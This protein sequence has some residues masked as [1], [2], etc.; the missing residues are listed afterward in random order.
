MLIV[1]QLSLCTVVIATRLNITMVAF[2]AS[3]PL[4]TAAVQYQ[5]PAFNLA[6]EDI[7]KA[8][9]FNVTFAPIYLK[10]VQGCP[11][12]STYNYL[13]PEYY[14]QRWERNGQ[15]I[16]LGPGCE[17]LEILSQLGRGLFVTVTDR[18][19]LPA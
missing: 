1:L 3:H 14:Y 6:I 10:E 4:Y 7:T 18:L 19:A 9:D 2:F 12:M 5:V 13:V 16:L 8:Y 11:E 17:E 15:F